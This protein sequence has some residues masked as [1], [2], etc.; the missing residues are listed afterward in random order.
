M[1]DVKQIQVNSVTLHYW[2]QG[3]PQCPPVLLLHGNG[4]DHSIFSVLMSQ[5]SASDYHV[6]ALDSRGQG[7]N[8]PLQE[9]HYADMAQDIFEFVSRLNIRPIVVGWSDGGIIALLVE[10]AHPH[11]WSSMVLCG[12]NLCPE[13]FIGCEDIGVLQDDIDAAPPLLRM[14]FTEPHI[15]SDALS[16]ILCPTLVLAG[17]D[18]VVYEEHTRLI[19]GSIPHAQL[20]ILQGES[21]DSYIRNS[22]TLGT[23]LIDWLNNRVH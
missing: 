20:Q 21:H 14:C 19:A 17:E 11:T 13:G 3:N 5:L 18:D 22:R 1:Q 2:E 9:Y 16:A 12:A 8:S 23:I 6:F 15:S 10:L 7:A 4:S